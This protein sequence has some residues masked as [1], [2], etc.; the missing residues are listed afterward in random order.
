ME[1]RDKR[2]VALFQGSDMSAGG[3]SRNL[4]LGIDCYRIVTHIA[5]LPSNV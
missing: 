4:T 3:H 2:H 1:F 5:Y